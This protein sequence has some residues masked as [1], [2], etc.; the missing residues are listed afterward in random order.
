MRNRVGKRTEMDTGD[1]GAKPVAGRAPG[2]RPRESPPSCVESHDLGGGFAGTTGQTLSA[3]VGSSDE[4]QFQGVGAMASSAARL[5]GSNSSSTRSPACPRPARSSSATCSTPSSPSMAHR[6]DRRPQP[7][8]DPPQPLT[9]GTAAMNSSTGRQ[10]H[11]APR[12][13]LLLLYKRIRTGTE[14]RRERF[15][16][17]GMARQKNGSDPRAG[18]SHPAD[19]GLAR[20]GATAFILLSLPNPDRSVDDQ[21]TALRE[22]ALPTTGEVPLSV[23][24]C[25]TSVKPGRI[26]IRKLGFHA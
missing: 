21:L 24:I 7:P 13:S 25:L 17:T 3:Q 9:G 2:A 26:D 6:P 10:P 19:E 11:L 16:S 8:P 15:S 5:P 1:E 14:H 12:R 22:R 18:G 23:P 4:A 20:R